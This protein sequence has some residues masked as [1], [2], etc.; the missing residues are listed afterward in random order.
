MEGDFNMITK[1]Y[2]KLFQSLNKALEARIK[3]LDRPAM[4]LAEVKKAMVFDKFK[5]D[6]STLFSI[7]DE[8][9]PLAQAALSGKLKQKTRE[10]L[11][12]LSDSIRESS[13][14]GKTVESILIKNENDY[15]EGANFHYLPTVFCVTDSL[16]NLNDSIENIYTPQSDVWKNHVSVVSGINRVKNE[17]S[18]EDVNKEEKNTTRKEFLALCEKE[19]SDERL[20]KEIIRLFDESSWEVLNK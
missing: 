5:D 3:E 6:S 8:V 4:Q 14:Y 16:L 12:I 2:A 20:S 19:T 9:I 15:S 18:W 17:L 13:S 11:K 7:S 1:R 10:A